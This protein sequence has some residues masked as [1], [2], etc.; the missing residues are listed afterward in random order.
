MI[1]N[2]KELTQLQIAI[3]VDDYFYEKDTRAYF[4]S[5]PILDLF[6]SQLI[7][8]NNYL[9]ILENKNDYT[10]FEFENLLSKLIMDNEHYQKLLDEGSKSSRVKKYFKTTE[11]LIK[12]MQKYNN[13]Y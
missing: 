1:L 9:E 8:I 10:K 3:R 11:H 12:Q 13:N 6:Q 2:A 5:M 7:F 4:E